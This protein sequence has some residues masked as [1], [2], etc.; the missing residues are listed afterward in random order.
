MVPVVALAADPH[1]WAALIGV[2]L[3]G[4]AIAGVVVGVRAL[5]ARAWAAALGGLVYAAWPDVTRW[6][7][8]GLEQGLVEATASVGVAGALVAWKTSRVDVALLAASALAAGCMTRPEGHAVAGL[9]GLGLLASRWWRGVVAVGG[10]LVGVL[11]PYHLWRWFTFGSLLP[12]TYLVKSG[13]GFRYLDAGVEFVTSLL[14][15]GHMWVVAALALASLVVLPRKLRPAA[16]LGVTVMGVFLLYMLK[17]GRDEFP[18]FRLFLPAWPIVVALA[19]A[20]VG[21]PWLPSRQGPWWTVGR[22]VGRVLAVVMLLVW[23]KANLTEAA[24]VL[25]RTRGDLDNAR[26]C[27]A[28]LGKYIARHSRLGELVAIQDIGAP[29]YFAPDQR[30][31]DTIG[32]TDS[33]I[34]GLYRKHDVQPFMRNFFDKATRTRQKALRK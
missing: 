2:V 25:V 20:V 9:V 13:K 32:L 12:N 11:A 6:S 15:G 4:V 5:G 21:S 29:G 34:T 31:L 24:A 3:T 7:V 30:I 27:H 18:G 22:R 14:T 17:V 26:T 23:S 16:A 33:T 10:L 28:N 19:A 8:S 1:P